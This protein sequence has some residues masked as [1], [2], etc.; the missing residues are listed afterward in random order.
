MDPDPGGPNMRIAN[1]AYYLH[2]ICLCYYFVMAKSDQDRI[3]IGLVPW[4][5]IR[6]EV[7]SWIQIR[8]ETNETNSDPQ[9][10]KPVIR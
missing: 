10:W 5:Q 1:T 7:K 3:R 6:I 4:I 2:K 8:T 9:H